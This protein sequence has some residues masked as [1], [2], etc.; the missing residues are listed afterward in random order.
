MALF[1]DY[2]SIAG[3]KAAETGFN[4]VSAS[5]VTVGGREFAIEM[6]AR[7]R[8]PAVHGNSG[9]WNRD[10]RERSLCLRLCRPLPHVLRAVRE[11]VKARS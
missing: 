4:T 10:E 5:S 11:P 3:R 2:G 9:R 8:L 6:S 7:R 1:K